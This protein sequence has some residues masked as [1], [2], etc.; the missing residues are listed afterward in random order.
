M[1]F[2]DLVYI[3]LITVI[4]YLVLCGIAYGIIAIFNHFFYIKIGVRKKKKK[5]K[6]QKGARNMSQA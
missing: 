1:N 5:K 4:I 2:I 6:M 3:I